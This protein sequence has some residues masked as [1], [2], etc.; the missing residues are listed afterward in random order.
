MITLE[1]KSENIGIYEIN[2]RAEL[3]NA[4]RL[5]KSVT[6]YTRTRTFLDNFTCIDKPNKPV[7][8][9]R[10]ELHG[11]V[12]YHKINNFE[13]RTISLDDVIKIEIA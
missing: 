9:E 8:L 6:I 11:G 7:T 2:A 10:F 13:W 5:R 3:I 12:I 4:Y 1:R